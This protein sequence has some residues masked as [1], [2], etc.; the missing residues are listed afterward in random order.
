MKILM[1]C[2][3]RPQGRDLFTR[4]YGRFFH[5]PKLLAEAGHTVYL[6]LL[7]YLGDPPLRVERDGIT[8]L[9]ES[10]RP[11]GP[12]RYLRKAAE[13]V[14][15]FRPDW[16]VGFSDTYFGII[17][18]HLAGRHQTRAAIDAYD[19]YES[20]LPWCFPLH[21]AWRNALKEAEVVTAAGPQLAHLLQAHRPG[22][23]VH[24]VPMSADPAFMPLDRPACRARM[25]MPAGS[26]LIGYCG[27]L[28]EGRGIGDVLLAA[29]TLARDIPDAQLVLSGRK[30]RKIHLP[31]KVKW[32][33]YLPDPDIPVLLNCMDA[34]AVPNRLSA[35]G[36]YSYP[37]KLY[38][39][40]ACGIPVLA[41]ATEPSKWILQ[42][43][44]MFLANPDDPFDMVRK[45]K[46]VLQLGRIVYPGIGDWTIGARKFEQALEPG[47]A[48]PEKAELC[49]DT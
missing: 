37:V 39:A 8:W 49:G 23:S 38:E 20:Y 34:V 46:D 16:I 48:A 45:L 2:K 41:T 28:T 31:P 21:R 15:A 26:R 22:R 13:I 19:N 30:S 33:G 5:L 11:Y 29:E 4:P 44:A 17:A 25:G 40:M 47:A 7:S 18:R 14:K 10:I 24:V 1:L 42:N 27:S 43:Q 6:L 36:R 3:R 35:F 32:M 9:S 12:A